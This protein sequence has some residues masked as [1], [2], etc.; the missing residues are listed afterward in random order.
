MA[1][2]K[3]KVNDLDIWL[4]GLGS[5]REK[6]LEQG[7]KTKE[8]L[9][10]LSQEEIDSMCTEND[11]P[12][13]EKKR[14]EMKLL[15]LQALNKTVD[16]SPSPNGSVSHNKKHKKRHHHKHLRNESNYSESTTTTKGG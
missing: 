12:L 10:W 11:I 4:E 5:L 6:L 1:L 9:L 2:S 15:A 14:L 8:E 3:D 13:F 7:L 16:R